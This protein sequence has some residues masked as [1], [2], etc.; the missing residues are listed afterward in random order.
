MTTFLRDFLR[1]FHIK[2]PYFSSGQSLCSLL[3]A[4]LSQVPAKLDWDSL[5]ITIPAN[6]NSFKTNFWTTKVAE[7]WYGTFIQPNKVN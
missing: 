4:K 7:I 6:R 5:I 3:I 1:N 2:F